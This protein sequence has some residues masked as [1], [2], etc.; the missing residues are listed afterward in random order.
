MNTLKQMFACIRMINK[1]L[2]PAAEEPKNLYFV[3]D[4]RRHGTTRKD[5]IKTNTRGILSKPM[6]PVP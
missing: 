4:Q 2:H 6:K 3:E 5:V 1:H